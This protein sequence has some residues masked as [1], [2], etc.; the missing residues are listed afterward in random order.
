MLKATDV[1]YKFRYS[2]YWW[3]IENKMLFNIPCINIRYSRSC[4][5]FLKKSS[6]V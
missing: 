6:S 2:R 5:A 3:E 1:I 4:Y